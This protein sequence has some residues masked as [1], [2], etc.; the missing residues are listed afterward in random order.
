MTCIDEF[1]TIQSRYAS[2]VC[3]SYWLTRN[4]LAHTQ[5]HE[6]ALHT[7]G[8]ATLP[9]STGTPDVHRIATILL[10]NPAVAAE[11]TQTGDG[12]LIAEADGSLNMWEFRR[13][14]ALARDTPAVV[15]GSSGVPCSHLCMAWSAVGTVQQASYYS[16]D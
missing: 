16:I 2:A 3:A 6:D 4:Y 12:L 15:E 5:A 7:L 11:W 9:L 1:R 10:S 13:S 8:A 14:A